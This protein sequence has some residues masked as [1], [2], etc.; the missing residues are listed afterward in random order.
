MVWRGWGDYEG[1]D[2]AR[3]V[4]AYWGGRPYGGIGLVERA[5]GRWGLVKDLGTGRAKG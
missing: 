3:V 4:G 5:A 2:L 1:G